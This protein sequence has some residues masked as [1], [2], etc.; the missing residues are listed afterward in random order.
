MSAHQGRAAANI[1]DNSGVSSSF[2]YTNG[3]DVVGYTQ[4]KVEFWFK[5]RSK[6]N[7]GQTT[8]YSVNGKRGL[9]L[10]TFPTLLNRYFFNLLIN[11]NL[12]YISAKNTKFLSECETK[13]FLYIYI[14][15]Q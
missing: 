12:F 1:Q 15:K 13:H 7:R 6:K 10:P 3:V 4:I 14:K 2:Y 11:L 5:A 8:F 9:S